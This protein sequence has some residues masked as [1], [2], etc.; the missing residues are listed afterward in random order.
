[1]SRIYL[2]RKILIALKGKPFEYLKEL[3]PF[4]KLNRTI[5]LFELINFIRKAVF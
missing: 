1:M 5:Y 2:L 3:K 4:K